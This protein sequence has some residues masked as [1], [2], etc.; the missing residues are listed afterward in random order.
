MDFARYLKKNLEDPEFR[1][2]WD[3]LEAETQIMRSMIEARLEA[4]MTQ[5][6]LSEKTGIK[7]S[8]IDRIEGGT[9]KDCR[10]PWQKAVHLLHL[11]GPSPSRA[12]VFPP[13]SPLGATGACFFAR[14][15]IFPCLEVKMCYSECNN[16]IPRRV[17]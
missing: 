17:F 10:S 13:S 12:C 15:T 14:T 11:S 2:E 1:K 5:K 9:G 6:Q 7:H 4:G 3:A 16:A 8:W